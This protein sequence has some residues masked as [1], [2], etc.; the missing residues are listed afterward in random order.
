MTVKV[1]LVIAKVFVPIFLVVIGIG[2]ILLGTLQST[3]RGTRFYFD[4]YSG[5]FTWLVGNTAI[6]ALVVWIALAIVAGVV[7][8]IV[9]RILPKINCAVCGNEVGAFGYATWNPDPSKLIC[10]ACKEEGV[11]FALDGDRL[12]IT[13]RKEQAYV[14]ISNE[15][16]Q[17]KSSSYGKPKEKSAAGAMVK[18]A[19]VGKV[20]GGDAGAVVGAMV[21]KEKHDHNKKDSN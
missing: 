12:I 11:K 13:E 19:I 2:D 4:E 5:L 21:A 9:V 20:I 14:R 7:I 17:A 15:Y 6:L 16:L 3:F 8:H 10:V 1:I 18:G